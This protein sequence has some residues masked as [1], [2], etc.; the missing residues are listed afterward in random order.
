[1][2]IRDRYD[3]A[4]PQ[5][6]N[7]SHLMIRCMAGRNVSVVGGP[8][9]ADT[10]LSRTHKTMKKVHDEEAGHQEG[11]N[12]YSSRGRGCRQ[13]DERVD[14]VIGPAAIRG[15]TKAYDGA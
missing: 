1:M 13:C 15:I 7:D 5:Y 3:N 8:L 6:M 14:L 11:E 9:D 2:A 10:Y 4:P 12:R